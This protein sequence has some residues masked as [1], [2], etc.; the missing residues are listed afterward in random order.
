[1]IGFRLSGKSKLI[2][3]Q[4]QRAL[5]RVQQ[6]LKGRMGGT[7]VSVSCQ[8]KQLIQQAKDPMNLSKL[9]AGWQPYLWWI[10]RYF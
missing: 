1:M 9:Y 6:R 2:D 7:I 8:V 5:V 4:A 3:K 10:W